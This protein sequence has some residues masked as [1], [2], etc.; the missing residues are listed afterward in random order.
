MKEIVK[1]IIQFIA[2]VVIAVICRIL[3]KITGYA[4]EFGSLWC[5]ICVVVLCTQVTVIDTDEN[6]NETRKRI[7]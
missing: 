7:Y 5:F 4:F 1:F 3:G 2:L 6:G